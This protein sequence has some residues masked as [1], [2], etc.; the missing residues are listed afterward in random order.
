MIAG[1]CR[2]ARSGDRPSLDF[3]KE[4]HRGSLAPSLV[5]MVARGPAL[6]GKSQKENSRRIYP[7]RH[8]GDPGA[9]RVEPFVDALI[10]A[11]DLVGIVDGR[12]ALGARRRQ[13]HAIPARMSGEVIS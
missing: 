1:H 10:P 9:E 12:D 7:R 2:V 3:I 13:Q 8:A 11:F 6:S 4:Y 5:K